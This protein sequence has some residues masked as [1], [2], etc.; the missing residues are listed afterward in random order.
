MKEDEGGRRRA[1]HPSFS[2]APRDEKVATYQVTF[3][4]DGRELQTTVVAEEY[5]LDAAAAAGLELPYMCL[6][7][8][9]TTCAGRILEGKV[10]QSE[11]LRI[12]PQD[13][14][15]GFVLLCSA[16]PR[17]DLRI[18]TCQ[19]EQLRVLRRSLSLPAPRG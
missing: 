19:K 13:E 17:S 7:G 9:C 6:Q 11:A 4:T 10:D 15:A 14:A 18:L 12:Y 5:L 16:F 2:Y 8:W 3:V 1:R